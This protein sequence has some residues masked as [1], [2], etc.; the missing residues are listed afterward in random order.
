MK[1]FNL[2]YGLFFV[3][4]FLN[5]SSEPETYTVENIDGVRHVHNFAPKWGD[6]PEVELE[7]VRKIGGIDETDENFQFYRIRHLCFDGE[8]NRYLLDAGNFRI[9]KFDKDWNFI[10]TIGSE[11]QGPGEF[12]RPHYMDLDNKGNIYVYD[13]NNRKMDKFTTSGQ[14]RS[15]IKLED[16]LYYFKCLDE[17]LFIRQYGSAGMFRMEDDISRIDPDFLY[18]FGKDGEIRKKF[19]ESAEK[20]SYILYQLVNESYI[21]LDEDNYVYVSFKHVNRVEKYS[22]DGNLLLKI[23][24]LLE[25]EINNRVELTTFRSGT[26]ERKIPFPKTTT[27]SSNI[28]IDHKG[29]IWVRTNRTQYREGEGAN[30]PIPGEEYFHIFDKD[31]MFLGTLDYDYAKLIPL[32]IHGNKILFMDS[33]RITV[34]EYRIVER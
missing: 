16:R 20:E 30:E 2:I 25:Y 34:S 18:V 9:Q 27:V 6:E 32:T 11:G 23:D 33:D 7:F 4:V 21:E 12:E 5:C 26:A 19:G 28:F 8:G 22:P 24:R 13:T 1:G 14:S 31:G 17:D 3:A 10:T 29:R 15:S